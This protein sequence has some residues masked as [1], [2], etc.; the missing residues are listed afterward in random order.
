MIRIFST[1]TDF[2]NA[3]QKTYL[4]PSFV[5]S[6]FNNS[7]FYFI[8][9]S[10]VVYNL[11]LC[12]LQVFSFFA[13]NYIDSAVLRLCFFLTETKWQMFKFL[14]KGKCFLLSTVLKASVLCIGSESGNFYF[15]FK[16]LFFVFYAIVL[17][18]LAFFSGY[19]SLY[20]PTLF[21]C[22]AFFFFFSS[23]YQSAI[24]FLFKL[25]TCKSNHISSCI[26]KHEIYCSITV[27]I[28]MRSIYF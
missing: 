11:H 16:N 3:L 2:L 6:F 12:T 8:F 23:F 4:N 24:Y 22:M 1:P 13:F 7:I 20:T 14:L 28:Y 15:H 26:S 5:P 10:L 17:S 21:L 9:T 18:I 27:C 25:A 19:F